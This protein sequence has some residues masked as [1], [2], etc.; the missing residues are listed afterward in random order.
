MPDLT[1]PA[2]DAVAHMN[3]ARSALATG[4][5][6]LAERHAED[7]LKF[8]GLDLHI[9]AEA[10]CFLG[11]VAYSRG[12]MDD[13]EKQYMQAAQIREEL[14]D[15]SA[16]GSL[17]GAIGRIHA[18]RGRHAAALEE[19][20]SAVSRLPGDL[21]LQ[22][23]FAKVLSG[24]GQ[25]QAAAAVFGAILSIEPDFIGAL[26][27][28]GEIQAERGDPAS[29]L[30]DLRTVMR[31]RPRAG[32][33]PSIRSAYALALA[34]TGQA[35]AAMHEVDAVLASAPDNGVIFLRAARVARAAG[36]PGLAGDLLRR[37]E[38]AS[39]PALSA[40]QLTETRRLLATSADPEDPET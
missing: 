5:R 6:D 18:I 20:Q 29:A 32:L 24:A 31:L 19:L 36:S 16:V 12:G 3:A 15:Q 30:D 35:K 37:A 10:H 2:L 40:A 7:A 27:G 17:L 34:R 39:D 14:Q 21:A 33:D 8:V 11:N 38:L 1:V 28:R 26:V 25:F 22:T 4:D 9:E 13:A 23:E